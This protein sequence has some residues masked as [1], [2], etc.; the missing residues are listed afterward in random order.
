MTDYGYQE[1]ARCLRGY[2]FNLTDDPDIRIHVSLLNVI[3]NLLKKDIIINPYSKLF[4]VK[5]TPENEDLT[6]KINQLLALALPDINAGIK[7]NAEALAKKLDMDPE[8]AKELLETVL[9]RMNKL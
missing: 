1:L 7:P 4:E 3:R 2:G 5:K 6:Q 8:V 9:N